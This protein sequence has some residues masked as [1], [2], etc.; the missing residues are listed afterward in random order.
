[1]PTSTPAGGPRPGPRE[2]KQFSLGDLQI[3]DGQVAITDLQNR[4]SRT[5]YDH[6]NVSLTNFVSSGPF[7][8]D[9]S[10]HFAGQGTQE[11]RLEGKGGPLVQSNPA[12][13]PCHGGLDL[14]GVGIADFQKFLQSAAWVNTDGVLSGH[15]NNAS[16]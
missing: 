7:S 9:A 13:T 2:N 1:G 12:A 3:T 15:T 16:E 11:I 6:I 10:V 4:E 14:K 8:I 5:V